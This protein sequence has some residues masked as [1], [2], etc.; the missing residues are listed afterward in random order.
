MCGIAGIAS[1]NLLTPPD[2]AAV[3]RMQHRMMHRGPDGGGEYTASHVHL[4]MRRLSIIDLS[5]GWQPLYNEDRNISVVANGEIYNHIELRAA[6]QSRGH[7]FRTGSDCEV[8]AHLYEEHGTDCVAYLRGMFAFAVW[9]ERQGRLLLGRDRM[10]EKPL[11][12]YESED[13]ILFAS[14]LKA[15]LSSGL[16]PLEL[17]PAGINHFFHFNFVPEPGLP[18]KEIRKLPA[19][20]VLSWERHH[21]SSRVQR[22]W[23]M[24]SVPT[25]DAYTMA[26]PEA[27]IR[28]MLRET[29]RLVVRSDVPVGVAL[30]SGVDS[31]A[32]AA[33]ATEVCPSVQAVGVGY[34]GCPDCDERAAARIFAHHLGIPFH[35]AE[36]DL[37]E[38]LEFFPKMVWW[39]DDLIADVAGYGYF[40]LMQKA[41]EMGIPVML[42]GHGGDE[43]FWGYGWV[44]DSVARVQAALDAMPEDK[45]AR[46][47]KNP[48]PFF[49]ITPN[50]RAAATD[51]PRLWGQAFAEALRSASPADAPFTDPL[52]W[53]RPDL[54]ITRL[55]SEIYLLGN[56]INMGDRLGMASAVELRLPL[57]DHRLVELVMGLR[58]ASPD[59]HLPLKTR[60]RKALAGVVPEAILSRP[61]QGFAPPVDTWMRA[62]RDRHGGVLPDGQLTRRGVLDRNGAINL[63]D[64]RYLAWRGSPLFFKALVLEHWLD[65][66][67]ST[68]RSAVAVA[69]NH[70]SILTGDEP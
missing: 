41:R 20:H 15:L 21:P 65:A 26:N 60:L 67:D 36:I 49:E 1:A 42:Q 45:I 51:M 38:L 43:L 2:R 30:S 13:R 16:T 24:D 69:R 7:V 14:E 66:M 17:D 6:L 31:S 22:Y 52:P 62:L 56:G 53:T 44:R 3:R 5:G 35:E 12:Y 57:V 19:A 61:K 68:W 4:A 9:D 32:I 8:I 55:I 39:T 46:G 48:I 18:L 11:Y 25:P 27:A 47:D 28:D 37:P 33:L 50:F 58:L 63:L 64:D 40:A 10:G 54:L 23:R 29:M 70:A 59:H 34:R